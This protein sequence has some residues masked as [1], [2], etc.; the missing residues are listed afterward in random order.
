MSFKPDNPRAVLRDAILG[1]E[2]AC[3]DRETADTLSRVLA[4][5]PN[6]RV[7]DLVFHGER[8]RTSDEILEE[9]MLREE[10]WSVA[11]PDALNAHIRRQNL[12]VAFDENLSD[13]DSRRVSARLLLD[14]DQGPT[15]H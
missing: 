1:L 14:D 6:V 5:A 9:A 3:T 15:T 10:I 4:L 8:D 11:G 12:A 13:T 7:S 2:R